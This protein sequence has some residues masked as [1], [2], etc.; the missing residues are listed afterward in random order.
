MK[1]S[2]LTEADGGP[3]A[4][5]IG[6]ANTHDS[7]LLQDTLEAVVVEPPNP[8]TGPT[9][10]LCMDKGY[11]GK[12]ADATARSFGYQPHCKQIGTEKLDAKGKKKHPARRWVV[13]RTHAWLSKCRAILVRTCKKSTMSKSSTNVSASS[14]KT[15]ANRWGS[16]MSDSERASPFRCVRIRECFGCCQTKGDESAGRRR[17]ACECGVDVKACASSN[18][19]SDGRRTRSG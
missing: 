16:F 15:R 17:S 5:V 4:V 18:G 12:P 14:T 1:R 19:G 7:L 3:V 9:Q 2:V 13:E 10:H 11:S 8:I 6:A